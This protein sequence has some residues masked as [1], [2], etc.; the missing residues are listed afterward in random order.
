[1][2][3]KYITNKDQSLR[4]FRTDFFER[5]SYVHPAVPHALYVPLIGAM[6]YVSWSSGV[7][8]G[9]IA[10]MFAVGA[11]L[12]TLAEY[13]V[14]RYIFHAGDDM[15]EDVREIV[16]G[17]EPGEPAFPAM[18]DWRMKFYFLAHGVHH[19]FP[20]DSRRL[21]MPPSVSI[22][23]AVVFYILFWFL[24]GAGDG[25][26]AFAG[27]VAGYLAYDTIHFAVHHFSLHSRV[28]L[29]LKK[30]HFR[31]HYQDSTNDFGVSSPVWDMILGTMGYRGSASRRASEQKKA[32]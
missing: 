11:L 27:F 26:A 3:K 28:M 5:L 18:R 17:L 32:A 6:I 29:Y 20:N 14:H 7:S 1:M 15:E 13:L 10:G 12:W 8:A 30:K 19:D 31:H 2:A 25:A 4:I 24:F 21:V 16:S 22:P 23:L 9:R